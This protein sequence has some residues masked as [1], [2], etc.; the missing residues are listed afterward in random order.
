M[1]FALGKQMRYIQICHFLLHHEIT[2]CNNDLSSFEGE[3][4]FCFRGQTIHLA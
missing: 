2:V 4:S 1:M 3:V